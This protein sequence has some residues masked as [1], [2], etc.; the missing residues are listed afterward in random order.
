M[1]TKRDLRS[2]KVVSGEPADNGFVLEIDD[3]SV[4][5]Q[6]AGGALTKLLGVGAQTV[7]AVD[8]V[9]FALRRGEVLGVVGE[10]GSGKTTLGR[11]LLGLAPTTGGSITY[12]PRD[13][14]H[15]VVSQLRGVA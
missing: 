5:Y 13:A 14:A 8:G 2:E 4:H 12:H 10:S 15:R 9:T 7:K 11:A 6:L 1:E 3:L